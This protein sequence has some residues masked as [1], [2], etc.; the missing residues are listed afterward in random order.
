MFDIRNVGDPA[1]NYE[2][3]IRASRVPAPSPEEWEME[4]M[5]ADLE[6]QKA[7]N[8]QPPQNLLPDFQRLDNK[9]ERMKGELDMELDRRMPWQL[10]VL[11]PKIRGAERMGREISRQAREA[12]PPPTRPLPPAGPLNQQAPRPRPF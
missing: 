3:L 9:L 11:L 7:R 12:A 2:N 8:F 10:P 1:S 6:E 5:A 4:Q